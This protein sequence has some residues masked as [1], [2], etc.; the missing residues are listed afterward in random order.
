MLS[1]RLPQSLQEAA[2]VRTY[3][4]S[5][6]CLGRSGVRLEQE[7]PPVWSELYASSTTLFLRLL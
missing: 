3:Q 6:P 5:E 4:G 1:V 2:S 7:A